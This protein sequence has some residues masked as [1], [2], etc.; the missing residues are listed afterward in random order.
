MEYIKKVY[1]RYQKAS[2][3][4][5]GRMLDELC[6]VCDY[7]RKYAIWKLGSWVR[8]ARLSRKG[9][10]R[11]KTYEKEVLA[12]LEKIWEA[13]NYPWSVRLK[14][15]L[16]LWRP[17]MKKHYPLSP[18]L[19]AQLLAISPSTIDRALKAKK[20]LLKRRLYGRT[21]PGTLLKHQIPI[22]TD[23]WDVKTPGFVEVDLVSHSGPSNEGEHLHSV[24][25]TDI[26]STWVETRV[27]M[28][29]GE[30]G[31]FEA[32]KEMRQKLPFDLLGFDSDNGSEFINY[33]LKKYC[34]TEKIQFTRSR[35]YKKND[36]AHIE[37]KNWTHV[38]KL[39]GWNRYDTEEAKAAM[40][41]FYQNECR[42]WMNLFQPSVKLKKIIRVG[43]RQKRK[44]DAPQ[45][46]LDRLLAS[47]L[48]T[49]K[50]V[51]ALK[52]LRETL[53]PFVLSEQVNQSLKK[54]WKLT[55]RVIDA[56]KGKPELKASEK[57][58]IEKLTKLFGLPKPLKNKLEKKA[59]H[60]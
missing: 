42:L 32:L 35:P 31:V 18:A 41:V 26:A 29:K 60:G 10:G 13:A 38:R 6:R 53:D 30:R 51:Q 58:T 8:G 47:P 56:P 19:E 16:K 21:K 23:M 5:K 24:N 57:Q 49:S 36:N 50:K 33:H 40:N 55:L 11:P 45:T 28:G 59:S 39:M 37:Q 22:K 52:A 12:V 15:I 4:A 54:I 14:A 17:W 27:V 20:H 43:S 2:K 9:R 44:Y 46:P 3:S 7:N 48:T 1:E 34:D 25:L